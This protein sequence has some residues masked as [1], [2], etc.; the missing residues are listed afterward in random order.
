M[1]MHISGNGQPSV[2]IPPGHIISLVPH[3]MGAISGQAEAAA[4]K[5]VKVMKAFMVIA[6]IQLRCSTANIQELLYRKLRLHLFL[7]SNCLLFAIVVLFRIIDLS[8]QTQRPPKLRLTF[9]F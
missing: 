1:G 8:L 3:S 6:R 9:F 5:R 4:A 2:S 7:F